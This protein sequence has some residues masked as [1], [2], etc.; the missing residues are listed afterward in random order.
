MDRFI[1]IFGVE[2]IECLL[3]DREFCGSLVIRVASYQLL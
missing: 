1:A 3:A 2:K